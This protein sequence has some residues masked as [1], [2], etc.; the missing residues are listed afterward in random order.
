LLA[1]ELAP[2]GDPGDW[3]LAAWLTS[4]GGA[5]TRLSPGALEDIAL[6]CACTCT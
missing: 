6:V 2:A 1:A 4:G 3:T 5:R